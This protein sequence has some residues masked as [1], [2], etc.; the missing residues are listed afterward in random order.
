VAFDAPGHGPSAEKHTTNAVEMASSLRVVAAE[1]GTVH[2]VVAHSLG[3]IAT[4]IAIR[5]QWVEPE[6]TAFIAPVTE[7]RS[8]LAQFAD[9]LAVGPLARQHLDAE[10]RRHTG[11]AIDDF[12]YSGCD[13]ALRSI[14][15]VAIHDR[16]DRFVPY[17]KTAELA[18][19]WPGARLI[20]TE[21]LG[22]VRILYD[23]GVAERLADYLTAPARSD[24]R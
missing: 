22:H 9:A 11:L 5:R 24:R 4:T 7:V 17:G 10:V 20:T 6:Q 19:C 12:G 23:P 3:A 15:L 13:P 14:R 21:G 8:S 2:A 18:E 1:Y 16:D